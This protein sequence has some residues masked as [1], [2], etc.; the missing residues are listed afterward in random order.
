MEF[1]HSL[2]RGV[3][4]PMVSVVCKDRGE[5]FSPE[6]CGMLLL[7]CPHPWIATSHAS[8]VLSHWCVWQD[9]VGQST[10]P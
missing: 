10:L 4:W 2:A 1:L 7:R 5:C 3:L 9:R 6:P 8:P